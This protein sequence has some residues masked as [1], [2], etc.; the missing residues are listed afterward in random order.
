MRQ[1]LKLLCICIFA[2]TSIS[3]LNA[4]TP[5]P[6]KTVLQNTAW[7]MLQ[8]LADSTASERMMYFKDDMSF[9]SRNMDGSIFNGG[10]YSMVDVNTFV[11][12]HNGAQTASLYKFSINN[13]T[14]K[15]KGNYIESSFNATDKKVGYSPID[16]VWVRM[17]D[18][19][20]F[21]SGIRFLHNISFETA[22]EIARKESKLIFMDCYTTWCGPCKYLTTNIFPLKQVGNFYNEKF[23]SVAFDMESPEGRIIAK[24][25]NVMVYPTLL[26]LNANGELEHMGV[27]AGDATLILELGKKA[28][29]TEKNLKA[30]KSRIQKGDKSIEAITNY[31]ISY[32]GAPDKQ[33]LIN[34]CYKGLKPAQRMSTEWW[35]LFKDFDNKLNTPQ[36]KYFSDNKT[37]YE[38]KIGKKEV[39]AKFEKLFY[40]YRRDS[41][42]L[43]SLRKLD[44]RLFLKL[45]KSL[46]FQSAYSKSLSN[47]TDSISWRNFIKEAR[48]YF[49][50]DE[51]DPREYNIISWYIYQNY[52]T[53][54]DINA[55]KEAKKWSA[56]SLLANPDNESFNDC[57]AH[58]AFDLG[59]VEEA[60]KHQ[61]IAVEKATL[62]NNQALKYYNTELEKF[63]KALK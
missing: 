50:F 60:I 46:L 52:N 51:I 59:N 45:Q 55:L 57:H 18:L 7:R 12:V 29:D 2:Q 9:E 39:D 13:D 42:Q 15:F 43:Q 61:K 44:E 40:T 58:I 24:K 14:L 6:Q 34:E 17:T 62:S 56:K 47:K 25:Y 28:L 31:L 21:N 16:E 8:N 32:Y 20:E 36:F 11:T 53:F 27:G 22:L 30:M 38:K 23:I 48:D 19:S 3:D 33:Q 1:L 5:D 37:A 35:Y 49:S 10:R 54:S 4:T 63:L 41:V 26:F